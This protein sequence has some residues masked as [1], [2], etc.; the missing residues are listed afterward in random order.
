MVIRKN[1]ITDKEAS[2]SRKELSTHKSYSSYIKT[3]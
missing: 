2:A 1:N 3:N